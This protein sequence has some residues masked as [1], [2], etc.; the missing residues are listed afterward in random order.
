MSFPLGHRSY[1]SGHEFSGVPTGQAINST[2]PM[3]G[4]RIEMNVSGDAAQVSTSTAAAPFW[5][6]RQRCGTLHPL[7]ESIFLSWISTTFP[8][9]HV[10]F[11]FL[12][13]RIGQKK[14]KSTQSLLVISLHNENYDD[15]NGPFI[16]CENHD[17]LTSNHYALKLTGFSEFQPGKNYLDSVQNKCLLS[18]THLK[19]SSAYS[20]GLKILP[21]KVNGDI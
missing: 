10:L 19:Q 6:R 2:L 1:W 9:G 4:Q 5:R 8:R 13:V 17:P 21:Q 18:V 7:T 12:P 14:L 20:A 15:I 3:A 16:T 11:P